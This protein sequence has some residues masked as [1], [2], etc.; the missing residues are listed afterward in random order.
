MAPVDSTKKKVEIM[1][2]MMVVKDSTI[3][4]WVRVIFVHQGAESCTGRKGEPR[5]EACKVGG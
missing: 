4:T 2:P 3:T 5:G 1:R